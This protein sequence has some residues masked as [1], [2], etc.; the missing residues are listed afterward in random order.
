MFN[1]GGEM[2]IE[3]EDCV[4]VL[5]SF[6]LNDTPQTK[7]RKMCVFRVTLFVSQTKLMSWVQNEPHDPG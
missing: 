3:G 2:L 1:D 4:H 6:I 7:K 5:Y